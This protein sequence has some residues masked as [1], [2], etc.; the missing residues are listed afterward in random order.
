MPSLNGLIL[1]CLCSFV[2]P[3]LAEASDSEWVADS[4]GC[5]VANPQPQSVE[6]ISWSGRCKDGFA[7]GAGTVTWF[8]YGKPNGTTSGTF[9]AG[10][11]AGKGVVTLPHSEQRETVPF[12]TRHPGLGLHFVWPYGSRLDGE[13]RDNRLLGDGIITTP[14]GQKVVVRQIGDKLERVRDIGAPPATQRPGTGIGAEA[15]SAG[16]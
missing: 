6:T 2:V 9:D 11:L 5:K 14:D 16:H 3:V 7:D 13:F 12:E 15:R 4:R 10:M 1:A 8:S